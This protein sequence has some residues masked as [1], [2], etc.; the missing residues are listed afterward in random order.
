MASKNPTSREL[1]AESET[2]R[3]QAEAMLSKERPAALAA[4]REA[5]SIF[6]F[7]AAEL[8]LSKPN[9]ISKKMGKPAMAGAPAAKKPVKKKVTGAPRFADGSGNS[10]SGRGPR[11]SWFKAAIADGM[12]EDALRV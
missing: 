8:G 7:T 10:W 2:L 6:G 1:M 9:S 4:T 5:V 12:S 11:P 3:K